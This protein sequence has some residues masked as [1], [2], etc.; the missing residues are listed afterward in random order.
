MREI[1]TLLKSLVNFDRPTLI[2][3]IST[4]ADTAAKLAMNARAANPVAARDRAC[5]QTCQPK[6][7]FSFGS[8]LGIV[9][10]CDALLES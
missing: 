1:E 7:Q 10:R 4:E 9:V 8:R 3:I 5:C 6:Y 2:A